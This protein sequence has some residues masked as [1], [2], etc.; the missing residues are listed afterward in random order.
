MIASEIAKPIHAQ[1]VWNSL[2]L[3]SFTSVQTASATER[4]AVTMAVGQPR[5]E[6]LGIRTGSSSHTRIAAARIAA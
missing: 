5:I 3:I 6:S 1:M 2:S 4:I